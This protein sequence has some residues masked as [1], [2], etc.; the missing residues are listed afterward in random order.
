MVKLALRGAVGVLATALAAGGCLGG[1]TGHSSRA[2]CDSTTLD[3][4]AT[5]HGS[6]VR[7]T[8]QAF[9]GTY[10]AGLQWR[11]EPRSP[12]T[13]TP[14]D[15]ADSVQLTITY[16]DAKATRSCADELSVPVTVALTT[17]ASSLAESGNGT[18]TIS[19]GQQ[20]ARATVH[21]ES[22][23]VRLDGALNPPAAQGSF[24]AL[25]LAL[26]GA[27]AIFPEGQ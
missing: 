19:P 18:L 7:E 13:Q 24:D 11:E 12:T 2:S 15:F 16:S 20:V 25:D 5:W 21:F 26:P 8:A 9:E 22:A 3:A 6:S 17:S 10:G 27:S 4:G 1:Q 14:V 23:R